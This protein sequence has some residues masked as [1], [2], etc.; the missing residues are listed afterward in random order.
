MRGKGEGGMIMKDKLFEQ[1]NP[2]GKEGFV[3]DARVSNVF[4][5][6][7]SRSV[8]GYGTIQLLISDLAVRFAQQG[9]VYDLGCSTGNTLLN[10][11]KRAG[12][13][14]LKLVGIDNSDAMLEKCDLK[15]KQE[16]QNNEHDLQL[17]NTDLLELTDLTHGA[18]SVI[19]LNLVLQFIT[20]EKRAQLINNLTRQLLPNGV[21]I[22]VEKIVQEDEKMDDFFLDY[23]HF[24]KSE[25]G[26][27]DLEISQKRDALMNKLIPFTTEQNVSLLKDSGL[28]TVTTFFQWMNFQGYLGIKS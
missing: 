15:L 2:F 28:Q 20:P 16:S 8:P 27:S 25:M 24:Y 21:I 23:F 4:D 5:D 11:M 10:V 9:V 19:I 3:F 22:L 1:S 13:K 6:M 17:L 7:V 26:Y 18:P 14:K 12:N